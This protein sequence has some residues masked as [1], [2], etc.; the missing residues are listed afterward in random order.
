MAMAYAY[1]KGDMKDASPSIKK[2]VK[3]FTKKGKKKGM[4]SLRHFA[5]T[6]HDGLPEKIGESK[7]MNFEE[8]NQQKYC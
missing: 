8:F 1:A 5:S 2:I 6:K 4:K 7:I 3:S